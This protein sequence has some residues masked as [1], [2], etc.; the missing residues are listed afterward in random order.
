[1]EKQELAPLP[2]Y[3][4]V[5]QHY[6]RVKVQQNCHVY[7][8]EDKHY[9]S[10][11][12][13]YI[14]QLVRVIYT[15][16]QVEIFSH[17][18]RIAYHLRDRKRFGYTSITEHLPSAHQYILG[19]SPEKFIKWASRIGVETRAMVKGILESRPHPEQ[20]FKS[21]RG[22]LALAKKVGDDRVNQACKRA[23]NFHSYSYITVKNILDK[24]IENLE[25]EQVSTPD[26]SHIPDHPNIRG[27]Q[28]YQ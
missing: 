27:N 5:I 18:Q 22:V 2:L 6:V 7:L 26:N 20:A 8:S 10:V 16:D 14:G 23:M 21:C 15:R 1:M 3:R 28:Y 24:G 11:P 12:Y 9:Y 25:E 17:R 4:F 19:Q 13:R